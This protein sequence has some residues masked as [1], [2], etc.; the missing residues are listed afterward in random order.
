[1]ETY[2]YGTKQFG[3]Q[4]EMFDFLFK[5]KKQLIAQKRAVMKK[6]DCV[7]VSPTLVW[8]KQ[9]ATKATE[10]MP[11]DPMMPET[12][13]VVCIINTTNFL[14]GHGDV[15][16]PGI[17]AKSL[18][19]NKMLMHLQ[20]HEMEF[21]KIIADG[22]NLK[23]YTRT[24]TWKE[25][26]FPYE[27]VTEGLTFE[28]NIEKKRNEFMLNQ[29]LNGWVRN[30]SVGM[31]YVKMDMAIN[32][33]TYPNEFEAWKKYYPMIANAEKAD[34]KGYFWYILEAKCVE[35]SAVPM[36]SNSATPTMM[37][38]G[39][40]TEEEME[41]EDEMKPP[42]KGTPNIEPDESTQKTVDYKFLLT[43]LKN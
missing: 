40:M 16:I 5:N 26:G 24:Y 35:G 8:D 15:H 30:H 20:E 14:D 39:M 33:E 32:D 28:S 29:Y 7:S 41:P 42:K 3:T 23:A 18:T 31:H 43:H 17:W 1:M 11:T 27:G 9:Q 36:G 22:M 2:N 10:D 4:K 13:K 38:E 25:L 6:A 34:E 37:V 19:E 21:E 12:M